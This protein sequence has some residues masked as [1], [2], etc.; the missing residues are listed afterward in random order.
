MALYRILEVDH[1]DDW[2]GYAVGDII[3]SNEGDIDGI[4]EEA[5]SHFFFFHQVELVESGEEN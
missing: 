4:Y 1:V 3:E 5:N 2:R